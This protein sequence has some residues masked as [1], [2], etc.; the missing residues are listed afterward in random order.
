[1]KPTMTQSLMKALGTG[2]Y[3]LDGNN[4]IDRRIPGFNSERNVAQVREAKGRIYIN[5]F[6]GHWY[7]PGQEKG[8]DTV[9]DA[10]DYIL[11]NDNG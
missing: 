6:R 7:K 5:K 3:T 2:N 8:F 1:M 10:V 11:G 4:I 9:R